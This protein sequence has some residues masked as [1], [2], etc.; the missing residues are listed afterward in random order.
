MQKNSLEKPLLF[1]FITPV[2][3]TEEYLPE[4]IESVISQSDPNWELMLID[5]GSTDKSGQ[6]CD[7]YAAKDS[8]I[9]VIH[10]ENGGQFESRM[11]GIQHA[12]GKYC[13]GL[14][15]DDYL[16][17]DCVRKLKEIVFDTD[18]DIVAWN[19]RRVSSDGHTAT[20]S[21]ERYGEYSREDFM[22]CIITS[23][24]HSLCNK[25][26]K[27]DLLKDS[28]YGNVPGNARHSEDYI[29]LCPA[30]CQADRILAIDEAL[31]NYRQVEN[32]TTH[33]YT[34]QR[35]IDYMN[36]YLCIRDIWSRYGMLLPEYQRAEEK[37]LFSAVGICLKQTY[38][39]GQ[40]NRFEA[41]EIRKH[42][43]FLKLRG[44]ESIKYA[45]V[46]VV[47]FMKLFRLRIERLLSFIFKR[48]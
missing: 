2:Y 47:I 11:R 36:S 35:A 24:N 1:S 45:T 28:Y 44:Y 32:S 30:I 20:D 37:I 29:M 40:L 13:S 25:L 9:T 3:N 39:C 16:D 22:R 38:K 46:D 31:Y 34:V 23:S 8:R 17:K 41:D 10:K 14:D 42:P 27:T 18:Y 5:D 19:T 43:V 7:D 21:M 12:H 48:G 33:T 6:I 4:C 15:S 26:I